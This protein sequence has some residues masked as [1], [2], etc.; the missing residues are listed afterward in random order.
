MRARLALTAR[1]CVWLAL[2]VAATAAR[3]QQSGSDNPLLKIDW[4]R[5]PVIGKLGDVAQVRVP[6]NCRFADGAGARKFMEITQNPTSGAEQGV[7]LCMSTAA[8]DSGYWFVIFEYNASGLVKDDEKSTLDQAKILRT[9]QRGTE[10]GN[11]ER[12]RR[13]WGEIEIIGWQREP[14]YDSLTHNLTWATR[15]RE[16]GSESNEETINHSVRLLGRGG[17]MNADLVAEPG[18]MEG[19]VAAFDSILTDYSFVAGQ[20]YSEWRAGDKVAQY[21]LTALIAGGAG[22][23]AVQLGL[24]AKLGKFL[25]AILL[26]LK[27]LVLIVFAA[28]AGFFKRLFGRKKTSKESVATAVR[29]PAGAYSSG[30]ARSTTGNNPTGRQ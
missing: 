16:K 19:A 5:G 1:L 22:V 12:R 30:S 27:K 26:A 21:G 25:L 17:V 8:R 14:Y 24:F 18:Q 10:A 9:I 3:A 20:R 7:L 23:A 2:P 11:S 13:G 28:I 15:L 6:E 4:A 29:A